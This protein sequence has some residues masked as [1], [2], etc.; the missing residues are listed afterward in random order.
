MHIVVDS[1]RFKE[2]KITT[3]L[4]ISI[5]NASLVCGELHLLTEAACHPKSSTEDF[6]GFKTKLKQVEIP[7]PT[8][9]GLI[10]FQY[11]STQPTITI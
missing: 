2:Y 5:S 7:N 3:L 8:F 1:F 11:I 9:E 6:S 10:I 4:K